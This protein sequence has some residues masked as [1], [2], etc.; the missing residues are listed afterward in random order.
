MSSLTAGV[1]SLLRGS[2]TSSEMSLLSRNFKT[3]SKRLKMLR[4]S[5]NHTT[6]MVDFSHFSSISTLS[7]RKILRMRSSTI[8]VINSG[9]QKIFSALYQHFSEAL[10][11]M[12]K[13]SD[14]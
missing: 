6:G 14:C 4:T 11:S 1:M 13:M 7:Q 12:L 2:R 8:E 9:H 5:E 3:R 10:I